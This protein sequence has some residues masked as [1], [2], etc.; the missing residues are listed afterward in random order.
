MYVDPSTLKSSLFPDYFGLG[1]E[2]NYNIM[3]YAS[4][5]NCKPPSKLASGK[6]KDIMVDMWYVI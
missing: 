6:S 1:Q 3:K 4:L 5:I 2:K